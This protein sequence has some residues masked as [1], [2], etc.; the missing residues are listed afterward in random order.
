[1]G[2]EAWVVKYADSSN[3]FGI[4]FIPTTAGPAQDRALAAVEEAMAADGDPRILQHYV[5]PWLI[6]TAALEPKPPSGALPSPGL[7]VDIDIDEDEDMAAPSSA[8][9]PSG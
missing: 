2:A 7:D 4:Q 5:T 1:M 3:A 9:P 8:A 6:P